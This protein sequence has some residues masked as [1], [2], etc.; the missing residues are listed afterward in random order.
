LDEA[1]DT[2]DTDGIE[3]MVSVL[4]KISETRAVVII[5]HNEDLSKRLDPVLQLRVQNGCVR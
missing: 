3:A 2:L 4:H 1:L 5:S